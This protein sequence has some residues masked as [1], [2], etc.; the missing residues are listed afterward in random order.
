MGHSRVVGV[1]GVGAVLLCSLIT[2]CAYRVT[3]P[4]TVERPVSVTLLDMG[5]HSEVIFPREDA[6]ATRYAFGEWEW[7]ALGHDN[8]LRALNLVAPQVGTLG[9]EDLPDQ[10]AIDAATATAEQSWTLSLEADKVARVR[11]ELDRAF[12]EGAKERVVEHPEF[13]LTFVPVRYNEHLYLL[14]GNNCNDATA[15]WLREMGCLVKGTATTANFRV[16]PP[17][18]ADPTEVPAPAS[19]SP[20]R[21]PPL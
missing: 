2:G 18:D 17:R 13:N 5:R 15:R 20:R 19:P 16:N 1:V 11:D 9:R 7:F 3:P 12:D 8:P 10:A 21:R 6:T 4:A 14:I